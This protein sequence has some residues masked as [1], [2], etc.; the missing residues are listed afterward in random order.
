MPHIKEKVNCSSLVQLNNFSFDDLLG[1]LI[2][3]A[4]A[5]APTTLCW[6]QS[7]GLFTFQ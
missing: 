1:G 7:M 5:F 2:D 6:G 4:M 3:G